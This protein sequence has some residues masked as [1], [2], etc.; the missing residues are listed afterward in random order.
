MRNTAWNEKKMYLYV[1][2]TKYKIDRS[3]FTNIMNKWIGKRQI[4]PRIAPLSTIHDP[5]ISVIGLKFET[6]IGSVHLYLKP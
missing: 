4:G 6:Y 1:Y 3:N 2:L 5:A